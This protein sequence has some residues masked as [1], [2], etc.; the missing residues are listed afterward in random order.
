MRVDLPIAY[1]RSKEALQEI[2][3][4]GEGESETSQIINV[5][6]GTYYIRVHNAMS[7]QASATIAQ[8]TLQLVFKTKYTDPNEPN[9]KSYQATGIREGSDYYGVMGVK[10]DLDWYQLRLTTKSFVR[11]TL[12]GIPSGIKMKAEITDKKQ[13]T[14]FT[15]QSDAKETVMTQ[16]KQLD[17]GIYYIKVSAN[18][19]FDKQYY[20]FRVDT[21]SIV[22]GFR[23]IA[24]SWA[25]ASVIEL[26]KRNI[27]EGSGNFQFNP[28]HSITRAEVIFPCLSY[29]PNEQAVSLQFKDVSP[30]HWAKTSIAKGVKMGWIAG[31]ADGNFGPDQS[32]TREEISVILARVMKLRTVWP[33]SPPF[34][35]VDNNRWSA[36]A[37]ARMKQDKLI[38][39]YTDSRFKP[40]RPASRAEFAAVL[41]RVLNK[42]G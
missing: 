32:I 22:A 15:M 20:G 37:I 35:D 16:E 13:K 21:D 6:P 12:N 42:N 18:D 23:D 24:G 10:D 9:N 3:E 34:I 27:I 17:A 40:E 41:L 14:L 2:D 31:Y 30:K 29:N 4:N 33:A 1:Q 8:Y 26:N 19:S 36:A 7:A 5:T 39:G 28:E 11:I 38:S 25:K